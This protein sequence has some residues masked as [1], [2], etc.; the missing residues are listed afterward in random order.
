[1]CFY[2]RLSCYV[3]TLNKKKNNFTLYWIA[4]YYGPLILSIGKQNKNQMRKQ[5]Y[6]NIFVFHLNFH[7]DVRHKCCQLWMMLKSMQNLHFA[8][9]TCCTIFVQLTSELVKKV[10]VFFLNQNLYSIQHFIFSLYQK[11]RIVLSYHIH[12]LISIKDDKNAFLFKSK[13]IMKIG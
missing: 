11:R 13:N 3:L 12:F 5:I 10:L 7:F 6:L 8:K 9:T 4:R 2:I 1:M